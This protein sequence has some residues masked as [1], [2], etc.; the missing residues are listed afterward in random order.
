MPKTI[1]HIDIN[2]YFATMLQQKYPHLRG[3]PVGIIKDVGRG[4]I[5]AA[6]KEAKILGVQ[7]GSNVK[8]ARQKA[9]NIILVP[10]EF[11]YYLSA[12]KK[13][14][15]LF[16]S[17][18]PHTDIFSLDEAFVDITHCIPYL[19]QNPY[20]LAEKIQLQ[21]KQTLGEWVTCN[22]GISHNKFLAKLGSEISP[23]G[24]IVIVDKSNQDQYLS[25]TDFSSV[26]GV[27][28]RLEKRLHAIGITNLYQLNLITDDYLEEHFGPFWSVQLRRMSQG[29]EPHLF[30]YQRSTPHMKSVGRSI[31]GYKLENKESN[32]KAVIYNLI[33]EV[34]Y[35]AR[36]MD[37]AGRQV[38]IKLYGRHKSWKAHLTLKHHICHTQEMFDYL[39]HQLYQKWSRDFPIIKFAIRLS[40]LQ[41]ISTLPLSLLP[42]T[43]KQNQITQAVDSLSHKYGL[44]T[45]KSG[46]LLN[47]QIIYPEVTG[48]L[49]DKDYQFLQ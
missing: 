43:Q 16:E 14:K 13:L 9:P 39:Y 34:T 10:A 41:P 7:T 15:L 49:G 17:L 27:G 5:I 18:S 23:K 1:L 11:N 26:C 44:F 38:Y 37:L 35:K 36:K 24:S 21:I 8:D 29:K 42:K 33:E 3:K 32:I 20:Q 12:T 6:S 25:T 46:L 48:F 19:Y 4:C 2:S 30:T 40:L 22:I 31:T 45:I 47:K 28:Y